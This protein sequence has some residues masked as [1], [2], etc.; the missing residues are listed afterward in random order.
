MFSARYPL[1]IALL[2]AVIAAPAIAATD[3]DCGHTAESV[4]HSVRSLL[5]PYYAREVTANELRKVHHQ[6]E[7]LMLEAAHC[8]LSAQSVLGRNDAAEQELV[9]WHSL[10]QWLYRLVN[11][12]GMNAKGDTSVSW[13][14]EYETFAEVYQL[15]L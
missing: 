13:R 9:E 10:D 11:F 5:A 4:P 1:V 2:L 14:T 3:T 7:L 6:L 12:L 8:K 15:E